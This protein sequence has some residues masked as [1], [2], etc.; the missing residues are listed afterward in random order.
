MSK[1]IEGRIY[2]ED[3]R[4]AQKS[5]GEM[6]EYVKNTAEADGI[7]VIQDLP[8]D[9]GQAGKTQVVQLTKDLLGYSVFSSTERRG[10]KEARLRPFAAQAEVGNVY[11]VRG[12]W[13]D[14]YIAEALSFREEA[15]FKDQMDATSRAFARVAMAK[16]LLL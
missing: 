3:S 15:P 13:N 4:F 14:A 11:L 9:P 1:D 2:I 16:R 7:H 8:Q 6:E 5:P 10:N 12:L